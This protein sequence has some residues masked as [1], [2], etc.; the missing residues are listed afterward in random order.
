MS[1]V[2]VSSCRQKVIKR[3]ILPPC[4]YMPWLSQNNTEVASHVTALF[5]VVLQSLATFEAVCS[6]KWLI[7]S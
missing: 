5:P 6:P 7:S 3:F 1:Y 2:Y 4:I